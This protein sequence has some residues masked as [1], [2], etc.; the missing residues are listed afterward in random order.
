[1][2]G[3]APTPANGAR[4]ERLRVPANHGEDR[5]PEDRGPENRGPE[6]RVLKTGNEDC[7]KRQS[8][9]APAPF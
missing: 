4:P 9:G 8:R 6:D 3:P 2:T 1:M 5:G 7:G